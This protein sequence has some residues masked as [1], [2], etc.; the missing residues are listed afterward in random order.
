MEMV[1]DGSPVGLGGQQARRL[2]LNLSS[3]E[4]L[5]LAP[6][7]VLW[8]FPIQTRDRA[9]ARARDSTSMFDLRAR[10]AAVTLPGVDV[11]L[12]LHAARCQ[13][14]GRAH[15]VANRRTV[16]GP[17]ATAARPEEEVDAGALRAANPAIANPGGGVISTFDTPTS[18]ITS[19]SR[20]QR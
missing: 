20:H 4:S 14:F 8:G 3:L 1:K 15:V 10:A 2:G 13:T 11:D 16:P 9:I 7:S 5:P 18:T 12:P 6:I 17:S 19:H